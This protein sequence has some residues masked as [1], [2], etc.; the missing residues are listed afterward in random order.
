MLFTLKPVRKVKQFF[1]ANTAKTLYEPKQIA[2]ITNYF[3][4]D[5]CTF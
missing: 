5:Y 3:V 1:V 4:I 2:E